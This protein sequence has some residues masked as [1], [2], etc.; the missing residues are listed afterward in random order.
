MIIYNYNLKRLWS[1]ALS[2][3]NFHNFEE[4]FYK[5]FKAIYYIG[6]KIL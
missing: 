5:I 3:I 2:S 6:E 1:N 4:I